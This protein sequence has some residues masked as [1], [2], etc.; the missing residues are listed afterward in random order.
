MGL[1]ERGPLEGRREEV[2]HHHR[3]CRRTTCRLEESHRELR[4]KRIMAQSAG[5][6][7]QRAAQ[8]EHSN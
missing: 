2:S 7:K 5:Q 4:A 8:V 3:T 1:G 6:L